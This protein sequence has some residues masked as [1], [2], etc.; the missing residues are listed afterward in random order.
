MTAYILLVI[1]PLTTFLC[2]IKDKKGRGLYALATFFIFLLILM[3]IRDITVGFDLATYMRSFDVINKA[4]WDKIYDYDF[5]GPLEKGYILFTKAFSEYIK[6]DFR[7]FM[8]IVAVLSLLPLFFLYADQSSN[9]ILSIALFLSVAPFTMYFS[10]LR[11][12]LAM[13][14]VV[15]AYYFTKKKWIIPFILMPIVAYFFHKSAVVLFLLYPLYHLRIPKKALP[16]LSAVFVLT[17]IFRMEIYQYIISLLGSRYKEQYG[18]IVHTGAYTLFLLF[19]IFVVYSY[20]IPSERASSTCYTD[21]ALRIEQYSG[22]IFGERKLSEDGEGLRNVLLLLSTLLIFTSVSNIFV[23]VAYYFLP[24]VPIAIPKI[25]EARKNK[26]RWLTL[27]SEIVMIT[28]FLLW[29]L[30][31]GATSQPPAN[32]QV[33]PFVPFWKG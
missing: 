33:F 30:Y 3:A 16:T 7:F 13:A 10:G 12:I 32:L 27:L 4:P 25:A 29:F 23:R 28:F 21:G 24:L 2:T 1:I 17:F 22:K 11:Q 20:V 26:Y 9:P 19:L 6:N 5:S 15:P 18:E 14:F 31:D 8:V